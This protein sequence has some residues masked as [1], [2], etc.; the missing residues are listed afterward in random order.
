MATVERPKRALS[1]AEKRQRRLSARKHGL[2]AKSEVGNGY[3]ARKVGHLRNRLVDCFAE[4]GRPLSPLQVPLARMW[5]EAEV[6][7]TDL[8]NAIQ[9]GVSGQDKVYE[10]YFVAFNR[11]LSVATA[12]GMT[13]IAH[14][15]LAR[16]L[17]AA[18]RDKARAQTELELQ[19]K[20]APKQVA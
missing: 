18:V 9:S 16:H 7:R 2:W 3:R 10:Q 12:L 11:G 15:Q 6:L 14:G 1:S 20:Y 13:P 19:K 17:S 4:Q 8:F 5:A